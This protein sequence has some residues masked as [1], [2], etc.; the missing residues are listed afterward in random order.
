M[1]QALDAAWSRSLESAESRGQLGIAHAERRVA[2]AWL[3]GAPALEMSQRQGRGSA[4]AGARETE[5]GLQLPLWRPGQRQLG[6]QAAQVEQDWALAAERAARWR[7]LGQLRELSGGLRAAQTD[8]AV[9]DSQTQLLQQLSLDVARRVQAGDLAPADALAAKAEWLAARSLLA[10]AEQNLLA[11]RSTWQLLTGFHVEPAA[12]A[13]LAPQD[14]AQATE[15]P[16]LLLADLSVERARQRVALGKAQRGAPPE[17]GISM[18]QE[19]PGQG[20]SAQSSVA[21]SLRLPLGS[22]PPQQ[23]QQLAAALAEQELAL[24]TVQRSRLQIEGEQALARAREQ[25]AAAQA[26]AERERAS[27]LRERARL[28]DKSFKLGET[29]LPDLL[30]ALGAATQAE[31]A[32]ERQATAHALAQARVKQTLGLFP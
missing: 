2:D 4:A 31:S 30:R 25:S 22:E 12:E 23:T 14:G 16:A 15:H 8:V 1:A 6:A 29:S 27:L 11:L 3:A 32:A 21:L 5:I 26:A 13:L 20:Q 7:L 9:A 18:R 28:L 10:E 17:L 24:A 19:Q